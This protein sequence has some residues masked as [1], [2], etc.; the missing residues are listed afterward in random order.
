MSAF[1]VIDANRVFSEL[2]AAQHLLRRAFS[3]FP[4][5][6][7]VCPKFVFIELFKH[8]ERIASASGLPEAELLSLLHRAI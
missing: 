7:F 1:V 2:I 5:T 3:A 8:K 6:R 4:D